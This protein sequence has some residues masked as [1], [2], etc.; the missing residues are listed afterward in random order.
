MEYCITIKNNELELYRQEEMYKMYYEVK[1][2][3][4]NSLILF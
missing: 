1:S 4:H 3:L 2:E